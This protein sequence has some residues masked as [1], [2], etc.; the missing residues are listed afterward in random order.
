MK[1]RI[2]RSLIVLSMIGSM[3]KVAKL[4]TQ[5]NTVEQV[6]IEPKLTV[7]VCAAMVDLSTMKVAE[8]EVIAVAEEAPICPL[9]TTELYLSYKRMSYSDE[10]F[11]DDLELLAEITLAEAGNQS[12]LGKRLVIDTVL[13]RI[14]SDMWRDDY[15]IRETVT[16]PGQY[17]TYSNEAYT[18]VELNEDICRIVE[19]E[20]LNRT[21]YDVIYFQTGGYFNNNNNIQEG[22]HYFCGNY[23]W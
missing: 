13:N 9:E 18:R 15:T 3:F 20:L 16:H 5:L 2:I 6:N 19:E 4:E 17:E 1:K 12:E 14:D 23:D 7:G 22:A 11:Y 21:N 10:D 8:N